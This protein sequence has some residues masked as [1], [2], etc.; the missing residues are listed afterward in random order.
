VPSSFPRIRFIGEED[1]VRGLALVLAAAAVAAVSTTMSAA[2]PTK[3]GAPEPTRTERA[4][5]EVSI[6]Q[7]STVVN[8]SVV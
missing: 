8:C 1:A 6:Q 5:G 3:V 7:T 2:A 4:A